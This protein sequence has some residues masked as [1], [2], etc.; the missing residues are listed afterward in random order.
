MNKLLT[1]VALAAL[2][3]NVST[4]AAGDAAAGK[5]KTATCSAC[6]G[7][8]GISANDIWPNLAAQKP[9]YLVI[10]LKAF[11]DGGRSNPIMS[12]MAAA[13]S[14]SDIEDLAAYYSSLGK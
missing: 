13:L 7:P 3:L 10:Q 2:S 6:H 1:L 12:P 14:D 8:E 5:A 9:G 4:V 11:R